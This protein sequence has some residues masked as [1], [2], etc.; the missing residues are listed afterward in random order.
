MRWASRV[1]V[2]LA[3]LALV[4]SLC[5]L[6]ATL[7]ASLAI[8]PDDQRRAA[9]TSDEGGRLAG[10]SWRTD[11]SFGDGLDVARDLG[12]DFLSAWWDMS[13]LRWQ[14]VAAPVAGFVLVVSGLRLLIHRVGRRRQPATV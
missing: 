9:A 3:A 7:L 11:T 13:G 4:V 1:A 12:D 14:Q 6:A 10:G 2:T 8:G 5:A